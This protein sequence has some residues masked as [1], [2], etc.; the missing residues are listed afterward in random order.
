[1][2]LRPLA[3][4]E[5]SE[6]ERCCPV[7]LTTLVPRPNSGSESRPSLPFELL[8]LNRKTAQHGL[9][10]GLKVRWQCSRSNESYHCGPQIWM[11]P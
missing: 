4:I 5:S 3:S 7:K 6:F 9:S 2:K 10:K 1:M 8:S 11:G